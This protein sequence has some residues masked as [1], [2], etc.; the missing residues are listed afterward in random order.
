MRMASAS[1]RAMRGIEPP[2]VR[3]VGGRLVPHSSSVCERPSPAC[4]RT[5]A[6]SCPHRRS[7]GNLW[8]ME[9]DGD[10]LYDPVIADPFHDGLDRLDLPGPV[11]LLPLDGIQNSVLRLS[12]PPQDRLLDGAR[13]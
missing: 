9:T 6:R 10:F 5:P 8:R 7:R 2:A 4:R 1:S 13:G 12:D 11:H 3:W